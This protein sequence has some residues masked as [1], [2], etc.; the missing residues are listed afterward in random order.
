MSILLLLL[1]L[2]LL[3]PI[4]SSQQTEFFYA[5]FSNSSDASSN[6]NTNI[7]LNGVAEIEDNGILRLTNET[8]RLIG[9]AFY[10]TPLLFKNSTSSS[11]FSFSTCFAFAI[12]PEY[13]KLG[14]H[15]FAFVISTSS[16]LPGALP[17]QYLGLL[18]A[19]DNGNATNHI[20][21]VE[22][23]TVQDFEFGD[24]N[25]NHVGID[26][27]SMISNASKAAAYFSDDSTKQ[28]LNLKGGDTIQAWIDY[29]AVSKV[30][31][32]TIAPSSAKP[33]IPLISFP[34]DLSPILH[35]N[36]FVGFSAS[37]GLLASSHYLFGWSFKMNG[38]A[39]SLDLSSLPSL[40]KPPKKNTSFIIAISITSVIFVIA[41]VSAAAYVS[42]KIKN[43][44]VI[45]SWELECGPHRFSY[46]ELKR[47]TK[48]F[49]DRELLGFGGFGKVYKGTLP[50]S[51]EEVAVKRVS[52]ES[53]QG[54][55]EFVAEIASIGRLRHR[56]LVQLRG[57]CR[58]RGDLILV[59]DYMPNGSLD[60][61][62]FS[63]TD[64]QQPP[65]P[66][67]SWR[68]RFH[69]LKGVASALLYLHEEWE[70]IV[71]HR[72]VKASNVL[73]DGELNGRLGDFGLA[74]LYEHGA[75]PSTTRVVGTLG[76]LAPELTR[77]GRSTTSSDVFAFGAVV[78]EV[79]CGRRP[80]EPKALPEELVLVDW[81]WGL[82]AAGKWEDVVDPRLN[83]EYDT[84]EV[85][86]AL[87]VGLSCSH[88]AASARPRMRDV[89][90]YLDGGEVPEVRSP[91]EEY[92]GKSQ[93]GFDDYVHSYPSSSFEK[94]SQCSVAV[95]AGEAGAVSNRNGEVGSSDYAPL[96]LLSRGM[97]A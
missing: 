35:D 11:V 5:G 32:V 17:S 58:R 81:V 74:K 9:R 78:L 82:W 84:K 34:V 64:S 43:A 55:R 20:F 41:V 6:T 77:T 21:A 38:V 18:N 61:Y 53:R 71:I 30:L 94:V 67:L 80:I 91:P 79:V 51:K 59:Y 29:D 57:W 88:P 10:P 44:D 96:A 27:N 12:V 28:D 4:S 23:D 85:E 7:S 37:T 15:G 65:K 68:Q 24:I 54:I 97:N 1:L 60:K 75:N 39:R 70:H 46:K 8:S 16:S 40:P 50:G 48:G 36:M 26:I 2:L 56:N 72:D 49:R 3:L 86:L 47:A 13:T 52:H 76:Y 73:L 87:K 90:R 83:R 19:T 62:L 31:N 69:I 22:F 45:E 25:D 63:D 42:Y 33:T 66:L 14:G 92:E 95:G 93:V 89:V